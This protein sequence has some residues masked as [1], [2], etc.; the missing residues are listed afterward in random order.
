[1][2]QSDS[3]ATATDLNTLSG[4]TQF[5]NLT[6]HQSNNED[7]FQFTL[8]AN[9]SAQH[10]AKIEFNHQLGDLDLQLYNQDGILLNGSYGRG[11]TE[12]LSLD[13]LIAG[14]YFLRAYGYGGATHPN[15]SLTID[16]PTAAPLTIPEDIAEQNDTREQ[17]YTLRYQGGYYDAG[18][19]N[20]TMD[21]SANEASRQDWFRFNL[22]ANG[23]VGN[24]VAIEFDH[25]L[26]DLDMALFDSSGTLIDSSLSVSNEESISLDGQVAGDYF[27]QV[28]GYE[29]ASNPSYR[30]IIDGPTPSASIQP[31]TFEVNNTLATATDL[32]QISGTG[33]VW[34]NLNINA[35]AD[36]DWFKF[37]TA[38][39]G[40]TNDSVQI[41]FTQA[42]GDLALTLY[43]SSGTQISQSNGSIDRELVSLQGLAA[44]TYYAQVTGVGGATNPNYTLGINA[45]TAPT[46]DLPNWTILVYLGA[47]NDLEPFGVEDLNEMEVP[48]LP[49]GV[50][51]VTLFD[52]V[53]GFD[54]SNGNWTD[55][56]RGLITHDTNPNLISSPLTSVGEL[57][58]GSPQTLTDFIRW[59]VQNN[60]AQNYGLILWN[61]GAGLPGVTWDDTNN[62]DNL[63]LR[64]IT[65]AV[66][67]S[68]QT[69]DLIGFDACLQAMVEQGY[70]LRNLTD[71]MV[72]SQELEPG[73]GWDY[74]AWLSQLA[75]NPNMNAEQ[76]GS[77]I[78][79]TYA[80]SYNGAETLSATRV[81]SYAGLRNAIDTFATTALNIATNADWQAIAAARS[82][83]AYF[84]TL[85]DYRDLKTFTDAIA[86]NSSI[87]AAIRTAAQGVSTALTNAVIR[88]HSGPGEG[89]TG[90]T[91]YLPEFGQAAYP[92]ATAALY[93]DTS[94]FNFLNQRRSVGRSRTSNP[95]WAEAN[96]VRS[97]AYNLQRLAGAN[98]RFTN[99]NIGTSQDVDWFRFET[100]TAGTSSDSA[101]IAF[102]S[103]NGA[104]KLEIFDAAGTLLQ[105]STNS[106]SGSNTIEQVNL[107]TLSTGQYF[108][109]VSGVSGSTNAYD[110]TINAPQTATIIEDWAE[111][112]DSREQAYRVGTIDR[113]EARFPGLTMDGTA[114][115]AVREDWF[116]M[117]PNRGTEWNPNQVSIEF[118]NNQG[119][120]D[121]YLYDANGNAINP[122]QGVTNN[123]GETVALNSV[124]GQIYV[125]VAGR[126]ST[127]TNSDYTLIFRSAQPIPNAAPIVQ[128]ATFS[129]VENTAAGTRVGNITAID[130]EG[131]TLT[132]AIA[133]GNADFDGDGTA[134][135][136]IN[137]A[138][139]EL[140]VTDSHDL[141]FER[142]AS[143]ALSIA[144]QDSEGQ[145]STATAT[146]NLTNIVG[147]RIQGTRRPDR[148]IGDDTNDTIIGGFGNDSITTAGGRDRIVFDINRPYRQRSIGVDTITDF[149]SRFDRW[150]STKLPL[151][152]SRVGK[153]VFP[154]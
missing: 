76:L 151:R 128:P 129:I 72:A 121:L 134:A 69:F 16:A 2:S 67:A 117:T 10:D 53:G 7:W 51:V 31:D 85:T 112:N 18:N 109:K 120:L 5:N 20:L 126:T 93:T 87:T 136:G 130:P 68:G 123:S 45:P 22:P 74:T 78:V 110:L 127:T 137:S 28:Y 59:G 12:S 153:S 94:W 44:G 86:G 60:P 131:Q 101:Q 150:Y 143:F 19:L 34:Q 77:A 15:Y 107:N 142:S 106:T 103:A 139:G 8:A 56:R 75:A 88:N 148:L 62:S 27:I 65:Q 84:H 97:Q 40:T 133:A 152:R 48:V 104:L 140:T 125:R 145:S 71:V 115:E 35:A 141:D 108:L 99:L 102:N 91:I 29:N 58:T 13:G 135:F 49:N 119:N 66:Q 46:S 9:T 100:A 83:A 79:T 17:A 32:R 113:Q 64:E 111:R 147:G 30:L 132:Y 63:T 116:V 92:A 33:N 1:M 37:T 52:R 24:R 25:A 98:K 138:T 6:I 47:D 38:A 4:T 39:A 114:N 14:T 154:P 70:E 95:D 26:G 43:N 96:E 54:S 89:G 23:I 149:D 41:S 124:S 122:A 42:A 3:Q 144:A 73:D 57:N 81:G 21:D 146:I 50:R 82:A 80:A 11:N 90:L 105:T 118:D 61:H 36:Q 55:T